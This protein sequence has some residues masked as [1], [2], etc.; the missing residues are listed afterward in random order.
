MHNA[1]PLLAILVLA[2]TLSFVFGLAA[3]LL[4]LPPLVGYLVAGALVGPHTPGFAADLGFTAT[5]AEV[6]VGLLLFGVGL[7]FRAEDLLAVWRVA[8]PG[9]LAQVAIGG[10]LGGLAGIA[11]LGLSGPGA[12]AF[13]LALSIASTAVATRALE[14]RG[15][16]SGEAG[17]LAL[18]W[19][20]VQDLVVVLGLVLLP[21]LASGQGSAAA[22]GLGL[23]M[24]RAVGELIAFMAV[25]LLAGRR[26]LPWAL[27]RVARTGSR[28]LFTLAV[29][30]AALGVAFS[31]TILFHVSFA[32]GAFFAGMVL[33][34][35][36]LGHQAAAETV[37]LQRVFAAIFFF[38]VG[39]LLDP[40]NLAAAPW[41]SAAAVLVVLVGIGGATFALLLLLRVPP[42]TAGVVAAA[43]AQI[44]E[45]SFVLAELAIGQGMLPAAVRGPVLMGAFG[46][47]LLTP[48]TFR[49]LAWAAQRLA[50]Q[51]Q[52]SRWREA[53]RRPPPHAALPGLQG[54]A[55]LV[56][57]G[58][59]GRTIAAALRRHNLPLVLVEE[60]RHVADR[61]RADALPVI[62][63]D[64]ARE[65]VLNAAR[66]RQAKLLI[67]ALP[68]AYE[69]RQVMALVRAVNPAI[70]VAVR[71]HDDDEI[72]WLRQ[73]GG[74]GLA[75]MGEREVALGMADFALQRLGVPASTAQATVDVLR[76]R[77]PG[78][79]AA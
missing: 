38:S 59:V 3:R 46:T 22:E 68:G 7:H 9:A 23:A 69:A 31:A 45:F 26:V 77:M 50:T 6:G 1:P 36:D 47:I 35:S 21:A 19:L 72:A 16:L 11:L 28:E 20:V 34:E 78:E 25:M 55:I 65:E 24:L 60:D 67:L 2:L 37:P 43:M 41:A 76:A 8:L 64:A 75:V 12:L 61:A 53:G 10:T 70:E 56:G 14:E 62:W 49:A 5:L 30:V 42:A 18:G 58:R 33:G 44:G 74:V 57:Y 52:L 32:L 54:H 39:M 71:T 27:K 15:R 40:A 73:E 66:P 48:L 63:G 79:V 13:G 29:V 51:P 17:R 4:R